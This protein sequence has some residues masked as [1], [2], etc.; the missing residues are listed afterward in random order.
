MARPAITDEQR[1]IA[2]VLLAN[3]VRKQRRRSPPAAPGQDDPLPLRAA[4]AGESANERYVR[5]M[6]DMV[7]IL[8]A[9][10]RATADACLRAAR[11]LEAG[12]TAER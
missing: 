2:V 1:E 6:L 10:G 8:F 11:A 5:G 12:E 3:A 9:D 4:R 7:A